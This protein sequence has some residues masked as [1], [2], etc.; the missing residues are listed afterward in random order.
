[1]IVVKNKILFF[2]SKTCK[3]C[4]GARKLLDDS[5]IDYI[6]LDVDTVDGK[7]EAVFYNVQA[8]PSI[9]I[10]DENDDEIDSFRSIIPS[11]SDLV[12][13]KSDLI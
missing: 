3:N 7:S 12:Y 11:L 9:I 4:S 8:T 1:M 5:G 13:F 2:Y 10:I 6:S